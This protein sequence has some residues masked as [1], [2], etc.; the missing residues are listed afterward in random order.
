MS[1]LTYP[2]D[3]AYLLKKANK[4]MPYLKLLKLLYIADKEGIQVNDDIYIG[5]GYQNKKPDGLGIGRCCS[6]ADKCVM[7]CPPS[8]EMIRQFFNRG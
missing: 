3:S 5:Q 6:G 8:A 4:S 2:F 1:S 7:G